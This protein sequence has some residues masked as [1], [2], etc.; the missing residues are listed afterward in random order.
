MPSSGNKVAMRPAFA[1]NARRPLRHIPMNKIILT[2]TA[3][4]AATALAQEAPAPATP[5]ERNN[6]IA[7][8][9]A[10]QKLDY[11]VNGVN[12]SESNGDVEDQGGITFDYGRY[13]GRSS[14]GMHEAGVN[15]SIMT[16]TLTTEYGPGIPDDEMTLTEGS[17]SAYY[18]Y[19]FQVANKTQIYVGPRLGFGSIMGEF[20]DGYDKTEADDQFV[21]YGIGIGVKQKFTD[22]FGITLGLEYSAYSD[23]KLAYDGAY[24]G[25]S[26]KFTDMSSTKVFISAAWNF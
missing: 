25:Y 18:N 10:Y 13:F 8:G 12:A 16:G 3:L 23:T 21:K 26:E 22:S 11:K 1:D 4:A 2:A 17:V 6:Y 20:D 15:I 24:S 19:N 7:I 14:L 9:A 5:R